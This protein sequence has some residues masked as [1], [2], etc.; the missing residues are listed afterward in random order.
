MVL[1]ELLNEEV[2]ETGGTWDTIRGSPSSGDTIRATARFRGSCN[3]LRFMA[4]SIS[5]NFRLENIFLI[6]VVV[7]AV[8]IEDMKPSTK[9]V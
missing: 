5:T 1:L 2:A 6:I 3:F 9:C 4:A 7:I 8:V